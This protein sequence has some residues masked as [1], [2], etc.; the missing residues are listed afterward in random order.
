MWDFYSTYVLTFLYNV[1][2]KICAPGFNCILALAD[3][4]IA[5]HSSEI[6]H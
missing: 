4:I 1:A 2:S 3:T 6:P 5:F